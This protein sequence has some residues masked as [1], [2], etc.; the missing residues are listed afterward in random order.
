MEYRN[1]PHG[2]EKISVIGMG[3]SVVG[4]Q[5]E[6]VI[7]DTIRYALDSGVNYI[8]LAGG[9]ASIFSACGKALEG[10]RRDA[11]LQIHFGADY[12]TGAYGWSTRLETVKRSIDWQLTH[13]KTDYIDFGF[14]HCLDEQRD[15]AAYEKNG[16]LQFVLDMKA[17]G[18]VRHIGLSTHT[19]ELA[20]LVLD[21]GILDMLMFSI[22]PMYDYGQGDY[23]NGS[24]HERQDLYCRCE[25]EGV[26]ISVMKPFNAGQL[27]DAKKS[28]FRRALTTAQCIQYA[29]D[30]PG[31]L[32]V[33]GGPANTA[34][35][36]EILSYLDTTEAQRDYSVIG[37]FTPDESVGRCVYCKHCHPCP[38]GLDIGLINKYYDL[39]RQGDTLAGEHYLT[40]EKTAADC[41]KCGRCNSRCP[42]QVAQQER[43]AEIKQYFGA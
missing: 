23:A 3:T 9:H 38:A 26:G 41:I 27:L 17:Q 40:L 6:K 11:M 4:E 15:L 19:P 37:S 43:M 10:R 16:V 29:L 39:A 2:G 24:N 18:V 5:A 32:T 20:N 34:Q 7:V 31:V 8:D 36:K 25:K 1:L 14:I 22:N 42:F 12:T 13:L 30:R 33:L 28:P 35:L 21:M